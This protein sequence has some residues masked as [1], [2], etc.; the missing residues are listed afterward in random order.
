MYGLHASQSGSQITFIF[1]ACA[2]GRIDAER[3]IANWRTA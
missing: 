3:P 2:N 1:P